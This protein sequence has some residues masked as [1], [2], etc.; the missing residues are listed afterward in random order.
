MTWFLLGY[1]L[2]GIMGLLCGALM[3]A[4]RIADL[5]DECAALA[6]ALREYAERVASSMPVVPR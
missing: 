3:A 5:E 2:G 6:A 4:R 1:L